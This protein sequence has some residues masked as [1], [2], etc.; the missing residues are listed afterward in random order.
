M[1]RV[2]RVMVNSSRA[3]YARKEAS[4]SVPTLINSL[5]N[6]PIPEVSRILSERP[7]RVALGRKRYVGKFFFVRPRSVFLFSLFS[8]ER[9][10]E[11]KREEHREAIIRHE[12]S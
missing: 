8:I 9:Q 7:T 12:S 10:R 1:K 4:F 3:N 11:E 5:I 2:T 6:S